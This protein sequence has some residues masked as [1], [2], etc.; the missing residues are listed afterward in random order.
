MKYI[1]AG[2]LAL[3]TLSACSHYDAP[4]LQPIKEK[5]YSGEN[6]ILYYNGMQ[7]PNKS[8]DVNQNGNLP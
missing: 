3:I 5:T 7:M 8:V 4:D 6:L 2:L 1:N